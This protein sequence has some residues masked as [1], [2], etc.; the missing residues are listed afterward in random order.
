MY[1]VFQSI[2]YVTRYMYNETAFVFATFC[3]IMR[4]PHLGGGPT[5][6]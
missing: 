5:G 3:T 1:Q 6:F 2:Y 4:T